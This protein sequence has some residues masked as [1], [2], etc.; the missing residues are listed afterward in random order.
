MRFVLPPGLTVG[1]ASLAALCACTTDA[2]NPNSSAFSAAGVQ[3]V[4]GSIVA[5]VGG[6]ASA[7]GAPAGGQ[8]AGGQNVG[9]QNVGGQNASGQAAGGETSGGT[10]GG[11][12]VDDPLAHMRSPGC[13]KVPN[14]AIGEWVEYHMLTM[15]TKDADSDK[16]GPWTY[17]RQ[18]FVE[19]PT[20]YDNTRDYPLVL[21][22]PGCGGE[23]RGV[24]TLATDK[25]IRVGIQPITM[26]QGDNPIPW[27]G[28]FDDKEG[29]DSIEWPFYEQ[30]LDDLKTKY[31]YDMNRVWASGNSSGSWWANELACKYGGDTKGHRL[32][33]IAVNTGGLP[34]VAAESPTCNGKG[35]AGIWMHANQDNVNPYSGTQFAVTRALEVNGCKGTWP[36]LAASPSYQVAAS[37][38]ASQI[39]KKFDCPAA[40]PVVMCTVQAANH[41]DNHTMSEP[42]F[43]QF[44]LEN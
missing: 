44:I 19:L 6:G 12:A 36:D 42:A 41:D 34:Q 14:Q 17:D 9:G 5:P 25:A 32:R 7:S 15:G 43:S 40:L 1:F 10:G 11:A 24:F 16:P 29:D 8:S 30:L 28:C 37:P 35:F 26:A 33:G 13:G 18:Y 23:A 4:G 27:N 39:C 20:G 31:C 22:G 2:Q 3:G 21:Q 38:A